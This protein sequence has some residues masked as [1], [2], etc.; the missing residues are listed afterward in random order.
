M[1]YWK[2]DCDSPTTMHKVT[3]FV[4][5]IKKGDMEK[6]KVL[7]IHNT[8]SNMFNRLAIIYT[9]MLYCD[10]FCEPPRPPHSGHFHSKIRNENQ[11]EG[12]KYYLNRRRCT[13]QRNK[14]IFFYIKSMPLKCFIAVL[15]FKITF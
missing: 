13:F 10:S 2:V 3:N 15:T 12:K 14:D 7:I 8:S 4:L 6:K 9:Y 11:D 1:L 5:K